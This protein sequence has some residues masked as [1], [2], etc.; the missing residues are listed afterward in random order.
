MD[1]AIKLGTVIDQ[2]R[3][4]LHE[5]TKSVKG[6]ELYFNVETVEVELHVAVTK[7]G[8]AGA[9]ATFWVFAEASGKATYTEQHT[10]KITLTL[11]PKKAS[12][13]DV[14]VDS[15]SE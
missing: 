14:N 4:E 9:K 1:N 2:L 13:G 12:G 8:E 11:K 15:D 5:L 6:Q 7:G 10:Q 3:D